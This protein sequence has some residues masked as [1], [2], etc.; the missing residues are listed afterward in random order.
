ME[1]QRTLVAITAA[2]RSRCCRRRTRRWGS[3]VIE[4]SSHLS[5]SIHR[6]LPRFS[7]LF[8]RF[9]GSV[10]GIIYSC[11]AWKKGDPLPLRSIRT[12]HPQ[13]GL[14]LAAFA[15]IH[16]DFRGEYPLYFLFLVSGWGDDSRVPVI[17]RLSRERSMRLTNGRL[18]LLKLVRGGEKENR[19]RIL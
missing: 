18:I 19:R 14:K 4:I 17:R 8:R 2:E 13:I 6:V 9:S 11:T 3:R 7:K 10:S 5:S 16:F 1:K 15:V 12:F